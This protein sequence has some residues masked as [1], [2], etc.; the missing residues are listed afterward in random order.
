M[1]AGAKLCEE[2]PQPLIV[3]VLDCLSEIEL[4]PSKFSLS[5]A[6]TSYHTSVHLKHPMTLSCTTWLLNFQLFLGINIVSLTWT[7]FLHITYIH[8]KCHHKWPVNL[9]REPGNS[10]NVLRGR[11]YVERG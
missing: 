3:L 10:Q 7:L 1:A 2:Q 9:G 6:D 11:S 4:V 5:H 8:C